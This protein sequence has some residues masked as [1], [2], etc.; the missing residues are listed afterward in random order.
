VVDVEALLD[1]T[2]GAS[3]LN[4]RTALVDLV[5]LLGLDSGLDARKQLAAELRYGVGT[6]DSAKMSIWRAG[7]V[8]GP[9]M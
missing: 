2:P 7:A 9:R 1:G 6:R 3:S 4:W 5:K 8:G